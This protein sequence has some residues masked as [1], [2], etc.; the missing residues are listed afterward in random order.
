MRRGPSNRVRSLAIVA[1]LVGQ[2]TVSDIPLL[3]MTV[4]E[5]HTV[6]TLADPVVFST[7]PVNL[8]FGP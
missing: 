4:V 5:D 7:H 2:R 1:A 6:P 3:T 8:P